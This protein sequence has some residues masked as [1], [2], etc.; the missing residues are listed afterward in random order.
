[1]RYEFIVVVSKG[2]SFMECDECYLVDNCHCVG[3]SSTPVKEAARFSDALIH[4]YQATRCHII[5]LGY[6]LLIVNILKHYQPKLHKYRVLSGFHH[7]A[8]DNCTI[9][10]YY[11]AS[12]GNISYHYSL[13]NN[14]EEHSSM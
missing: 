7:E 6:F 10:D 3:E 4:T 11:S 5:Q 8:A 9:L 2:T 13:R 14:P 1:V 12:T